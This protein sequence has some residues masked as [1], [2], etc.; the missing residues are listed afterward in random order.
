[1]KRFANDDRL[2]INRGG[3]FYMV[4][5]QRNMGRT[6]SRTEIDM[7]DKDSDGYDLSAPANQK[8]QITL[9]VTPDYPDVNGFEY[10]H[11]LSSS[12]PPVAEFFQIR[13]NGAAGN[14]TSAK[15]GGDLLFHGSCY[16]INCNETSNK[17]GVRSYAVT[18]VLGAKPILDIT[19]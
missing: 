14:A 1:M 8:V 7:S 17:D 19:G 6:R 16:V 15:L 2:W 3:T 11:D 9:E 12:N 4:K 13:K 10:I 5:G 18:L